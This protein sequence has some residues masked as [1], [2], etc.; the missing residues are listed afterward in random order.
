MAGTQLIRFDSRVG[1][2]S[3]VGLNLRPSLSFDEWQQIGGQLQQAERAVLWW[4]GDW[5]NYGERAYGEM[6]SQALEETEY[7]EKTLRNAKYVAGAVELSRRRDTLA[8]GIHAEIA[9]LPPDQ[10]DATLA[11]A[12]R[13]SLTVREVRERVNALKRGI[14]S[15]PQL[16]DGKYSLIYADPPWR[17]DHSKTDSRRV[18]NQYP[19]MELD[20]IRSLPVA[21]VAA[22]D[23]VL[24]LWATS[25]KLAEAMTVIEAWGFTYRTCAV[26]DK[27]V[28]GM[29]YYFRQQHEL[30]LVATRGEPAAPDESVRESSVIHARRGEHSAK[31]IEVYELIERMYP[32]VPR[33]ELFARETREGWSSWGN[34][35]AA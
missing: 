18:E 19:T 4:L 25:P 6:Y 10:Q 2:I 28:I 35:I 31:P 33:V 22:D 14:V 7:A 3:A 16:P 21:D 29:G 13:E 5:L 32:T 1:D 20:A 8:W 9:S 24:F 34:Q 26:W 30:L 23:C 27:Q 12:E 11:E 15:V 17:Y